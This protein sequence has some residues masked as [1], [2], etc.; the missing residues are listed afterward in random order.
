MD[1]YHTGSNNS[2]QHANVGR[3]ISSVV[4]SLSNDASRKFIY[5]E[6][7]FF[8]RWYRAQSNATQALV[9]RLVESKQLT[10]VNGGWW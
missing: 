8:Q 3:L 2:I 7:A 1:Q 9:R 6:I 10:F 5:A 4:E